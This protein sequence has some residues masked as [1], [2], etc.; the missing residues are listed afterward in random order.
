MKTKISS[1][2]LLLAAVLVFACTTKSLDPTLS[3]SKTVENGVKSTSD[4]KALILGAYVALKHEEYYGRGLIILNEVRGI[5]TFSNGFSGRYTTEASLAYNTNNA[6]IWNSSIAFRV[7]ASANLAIGTDIS[8]FPS[9]LDKAKHLKGEAYALRALVHFD[10]LKEY[11]QINT[12]GNWGIPYI[13][14]YKSKE[15]YPKR[16]TIDAVKTKILADLDMA[17]NLMSDDF[18][19][20]S[21]TTMSKY[22]AK[23]LECRVSL[24]FRDWG[25]ARDAAKTVIDSRK[26]EIVSAQDFVSSWEKD[27]NKNSLFELAFSATENLSS[28]AIA[29]IYRLQAPGSGYGDIQALD[30]VL[31]IFSDTDVRKDI[32]GYQ[33]E[34]GALRNMGKYPDIRGYNNVP[35]VRYEEVILSYAEALFELGSVAQATAQLNLIATNR[36][37]TPYAKVTRENILAERRKELMFEGFIFDD[38][39]R[40]KKGIPKVSE[41]QNI[42]ES[43]P[44]GDPRLALPI[45]IGEMNSN[46]NME[47]NKG[48]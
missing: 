4:L 28:N 32:I 27:S 23:A 7:I 42:S 2:V 37:V 40:T 33:F 48:Y 1:Y 17:Y 10:L 22:T 36:G 46:P 25:R 6:Y 8:K 16:E 45:P 13:M 29:F 19:D 3:Q 44:Y 30:D 26:Y 15:L 35:L 38:L 5:N 31:D 24:Y 9:A 18:F 20:A 43:I 34:D 47:Q 41:Q 11:G 39:M 14:E 21:K 12:G